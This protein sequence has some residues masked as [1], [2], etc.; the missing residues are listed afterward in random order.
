MYQWK[1]AAYLW[2]SRWRERAALT[3]PPSLT[4]RLLKAKAAGTADLMPG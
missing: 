4:S 3:P 1:W 2:E